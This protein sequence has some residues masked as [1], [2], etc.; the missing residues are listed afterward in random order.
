MSLLTALVVASLAL[1]ALIFVLGR[2]RALAGFALL[3]ASFELLLRLGYVLLRVP[4]THW[5][6]IGGAVLAVAGSALWVRAQG[7]VE[8]SLATALI[9]VALV[10][11]LLVH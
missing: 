1:A 9:C 7:K 10:Q 6:L 3:I 11:M 4:D 8:P 5:G 2:Q